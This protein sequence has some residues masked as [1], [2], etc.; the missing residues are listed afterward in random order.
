MTKRILITSLGVRSKIQELGYYYI[1]EGNRHIYCDAL[2]PA[3]AG[4]KYI[5]S[6]YEV[7]TIITFGRDDGDRKLDIDDTTGIDE[8]KK[9]YDT[10][11]NNM[12]AYD[13]F[14]YRMA[15]F[16]EEENF[17]SK[18]IMGTLDRKTRDA[19]TDL[20]DK[21][22]K[23]EEKSNE[24]VKDNIAFDAFVKDKAMCQRL[25]AKVDKWADELNVDNE[26]LIDWVRHFIY[27]EMRDNRK[28]QILEENEDANLVFIPIGED[29]ES[30]EAFVDVLMENLKKINKVQR[31]Y[32]NDVEVF[33]CVQNDEARDIFVILTLLET[34]KTMPGSKVRVNKIIL[35]ESLYHNIA[36][37]IHDDTLKN[38]VSEMI[39]GAKAFLRYGR[40]D[41]LL[42]TWAA[43]G[44][45]NPEIEHILYAI[46][47]IDTGISLCDVTDV[48]RGLR[49]L[50]KYYNKSTYIEGDTFVEKYFNVIAGGIRQDY[51]KLLE[52]DDI[53]FIELVKWAYRKGF[54]QQTL[55]FIESRAP[56]DFVDKGIFYYCDKN[57]DRKKVVEKLGRIYYNLKPFEKY[58]LSDVSHYYIK[59]YNRWKTPRLD[60][61]NEYQLEYT[62]T[63]MRE[64]D[65]V[66][67]DTIKA[68]S[69]C[70]DREALRDLLFAYYYLGD[71]RNSTNH[72]ADEFGGFIDVMDESDISER[73]NLIKKTID[74]FLLC[75]DNVVNNLSDDKKKDV[76]H[77]EAAELS[78]YANE[79][80]REYR[81]AKK[82]NKER[83]KKE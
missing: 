14:S 35:T 28:L 75:Y 17:E 60:N 15:Q 25:E 51:G 29:V 61:S 66:D 23:E 59:F 49:S 54:Y 83:D 19:V 56:R 53:E 21:T 16:L 65:E 47:N 81:A 48:E 74:F 24:R 70:T 5:L 38:S 42:E 36:N 11:I 63:R 50:K 18:N 8:G 58:K 45:E 20:L 34:I 77:I 82:D 37:Q 10:D 9:L 31:E 33:L 64:L 80:R 76:E 39:S 55:T 46:K 12:T 1:S 22:I 73:M 26:V 71:V 30:K 40:A 27:L 44:L 13:L 67:K 41:M 52:G 32:D 72:A 6:N 78:D 2:S 7:D 57:E 4:C 69:I 62:K 68:H 43:S 3:E 79:L